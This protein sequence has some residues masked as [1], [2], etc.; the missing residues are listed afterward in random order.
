MVTE[1]WECEAAMSEPFGATIVLPTGHPPVVQLCPSCFQTHYLPL[2]AE[3][4]ADAVRRDPP[5]PTDRTPQ[6]VRRTLL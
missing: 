5:I 4:S 2:I 6:D 1:C 3:I